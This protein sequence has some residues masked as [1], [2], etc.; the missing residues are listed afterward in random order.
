MCPQCGTRDED[1]D[2]GLPGQE[3]RYTIA[4]HRCVGCEVIAD[5]QAELADSGEPINGMKIQLVPVAA[6][7]AMDLIRDLT[8][9]HDD[10]SDDE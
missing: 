9:Q 6:Q 8:R 4:L 1:W 3:D 7:A 5:K 10:D 2:H